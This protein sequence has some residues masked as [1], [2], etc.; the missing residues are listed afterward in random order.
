M[1]WVWSE[2]ACI[3]AIVYVLV[4]LFSVFGHVISSSYVFRS[5]I[6]CGT[7]SVFRLILCLW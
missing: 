5:F 1:T 7:H 4:I 3:S 6:D 2:G